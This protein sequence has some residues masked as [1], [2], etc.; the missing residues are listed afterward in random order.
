M[1]EGQD[2]ERDETVSTAYADLS[3]ETTSSDLDARIMQAAQPSSRLSNLLALKPL[4][5]AAITVLSVGLVLELQR[6]TPA[7][8]T[9]SALTAPVQELSLERQAVV[10]ETVSD[11]ADDADNLPAA[12]VTAEQ[13][14]AEPRNRS[15]RS[16]RE[17]AAI[18]ETLDVAP[19][20]PAARLY[21]DL[22][23]LKV[24][25]PAPR[26]CDDIERVDASSWYSC[27]LRLREEGRDDEASFELSLLMSK[28]PDFEI[29]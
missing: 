1:S 27:V 5:W 16:V 21:E 15:L 29:R 3:R 11:F 28:Y 23:N 20:I 4:S 18:S 26:H 25:P 17:E 22:D 24:E 12:G 7:I 19:A 6:S 14:I 13:P 9:D 2:M 10:P 8:S